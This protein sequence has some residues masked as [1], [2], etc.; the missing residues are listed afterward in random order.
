MW[1]VI[2]LVIVAADTATGATV[3]TSGGWLAAL[4][5]LVFFLVMAW[6]FLVPGLVLAP[7]PAAPICAVA[8]AAVA[9]R[10]AWVDGS[11]FSG[12]RDPASWVGPALAT[13]AI[14]LAMVAPFTGVLDEVSRPMLFPLRDGRWLAVEGDGRIFNH[15]WPVPAQRGAWD[16]VR[17]GSNG[18]SR[19]GFRQAADG[20]FAAYG[21]P[22]VAPCDGTVVRAV[23]GLADGVPTTTH[24]AGNHVVID[25]GSERVVLAHLH[26]G[27]VRVEQGQHVTAGVVLGEVGNSGNSTEPHLHIHAERDGVPLRLRF[28]DVRRR[29]GKGAV[30]SV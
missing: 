12:F 2:W 5:A 3:S 11:P 18:R 21:A 4:G 15:H 23:D 9:V 30:I 19:R 26:Y 25:T 20:D 14:A 17:L 10:G 13:G 24:P 27:S 28:D 7:V 29:V 22:V 1:P 16:L 8:T 6:R